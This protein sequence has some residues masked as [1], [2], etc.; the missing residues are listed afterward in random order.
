MK[1]LLVRVGLFSGFLL[2]KSIRGYELG[3]KVDT[4][5]E[6]KLQKSLAISLGLVD[7][8]LLMTNDLQDFTF[9][10]FEGNTRFFAAQK[11]SGFLEFSDNK[12][13]V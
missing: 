13:L 8:I 2:V 11:L 9:F 7:L 10:A 12:V 3:F 5:V 6:N 4:T 1:R